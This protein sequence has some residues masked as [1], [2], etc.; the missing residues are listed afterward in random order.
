M[1][2]LESPPEQTLTEVL[3]ALPEIAKVNEDDLN[4]IFGLRDSF[5]LQVRGRT[6]YPSQRRFSNA[7]IKSVFNYNGDILATEFTRQ[8]GKTT[9]VTETVGFIL[10]FYYQICWRLGLFSFPAFNVGFFA[11]Q[12]Q[13]TFSSFQMLK[14]FLTDAK[15]KVGFKFN[16]DTFNGDTITITEDGVP[17]RQAYCFTASPTSNPESKTLHLILYDE[18]QDLIDMKVEKS[19]EPMGASTNATQV[20]IGVAGYRRCKFWKYLQNLP[21]ENKFVIPVTEA[22]KEREELYRST[23]NLIHLFYKK[24]LEKKLRL[25]GIDENSDHYKTQYLLQWILE[26][27]Q[28]ITYDDLM[29]LE[30]DYLIEREW[31]SAIHCY[32]GIDWGKMKDSTVLTV[33]DIEG[34]IIGWH[35]WIGDNYNV[36]FEEIADLIRDRYHGMKALHCDATATQDM[37]VDQMRG[38]L[39]S[40]SHPCKVIGVKFTSESKD[41]MYK[42]LSRLMTKVSKM[43]EGKEIIIRNAVL[44]FPLKYPDMQKK[45]KFIIQFTDLQKDVKN[46]RWKCDHPEGPQYHDDYTDSL[47]LACIAFKPVTVPEKN[48]WLVA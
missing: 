45:E 5:V 40:R 42:N 12:Q 26:R 3:G 44:Q 47:A 11:P 29:L 35:E 38:A 16:F 30:K 1:T 25:E 7:V 10:L 43:V 19:I 14:D 17:K 48:R 13:Q 39:M 9:I 2:S 41:S 36:Q 4:T 6:Y 28:F 31:G 8:H 27:G 24:H 22:L 46:E 32:G 18:S 33:V 23:G 21:A 20:F 37:G 34:R 15:D